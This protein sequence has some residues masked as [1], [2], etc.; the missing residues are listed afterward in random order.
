M[1]TRFLGY[2]G[3]PDL[4]RLLL[5]TH[6]A[7]LYPSILFGFFIFGFIAV[8]RKGRS[9]QL[10]VITMFCLLLMSS[11]LG[12]TMLPFVH[13]QRYSSVAESEESATYL[14]MVDASGEEI[15]LDRRAIG[16]HGSNLANQLVAIDHRSEQMEL[17][18]RIIEDAERYRERVVSPIPR[19]RHPPSAAGVT[20][21]REDVQHLK[22]FVG[23]R[24]YHAEWSYERN[25]HEVA[26]IDH[27]CL[28]EIFPDEDIA[29]PTCEHV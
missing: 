28:F 4:L 10:F 11:Q 29:R 2:P 21:S 16:P 5:D 23:V 1:P 17:S 25:S 7:I 8:L 22:G 27:E 14:V 3:L 15:Q 20:W 12:V 13:A 9:R 26:S 19:L 24:V 6:G 18:E